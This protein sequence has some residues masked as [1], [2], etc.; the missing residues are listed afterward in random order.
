MSMSPTE[1]AAYKVWKPMQHPEEP[2]QRKLLRWLIPIAAT[3]ALAWHAGCARAESAEGATYLCVDKGTIDDVNPVPKGSTAAGILGKD[4]RRYAYRCVENSLYLCNP[5]RRNG[6]GCVR[7]FR[8]DDWAEANEDFGT[9]SEFGRVAGPSLPRLDIQAYCANSNQ[10]VAKCQRDEARSLAAL[11]HTWPRMP[12]EVR[13]RCLG[14]AQADS[15]SASYSGIE[16]CI[17]D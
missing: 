16:V 10:G 1:R 5:S 9:I 12:A 17:W 15:T 11:K 2:S 4:A 6:H 14:D 7:P 13:K 8:D 3:M